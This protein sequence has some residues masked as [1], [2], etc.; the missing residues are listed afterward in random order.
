[1]KTIIEDLKFKPHPAG[2]VGGTAARVFFDNGYGASVVT[3]EYFYS[4]EDAP[5]EIGVLKGDK[6]SSTLTYDTPITDDVI[7]Y[8]T[9]SE[10]NTILDA[11]AALPKAEGEI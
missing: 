3:G 8:R 5:Y 4:S 9:E 2:G 1:M 10:T 11:I 7:G 6:D